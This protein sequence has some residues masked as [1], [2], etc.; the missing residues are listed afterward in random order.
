MAL[1]VARN[2]PYRSILSAIVCVRARSKLSE[3]E[4][5]EKIIV[6]DLEKTRYINL[7]RTMGGTRWESCLMAVKSKCGLLFS[8]QDVIMPS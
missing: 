6:Y 3:V 4:R 5:L 1:R 2:Q 8:R 7:W